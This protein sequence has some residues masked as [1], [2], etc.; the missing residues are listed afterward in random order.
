LSQQLA[1]LRENALDK[2]IYC[3]LAY[4]GVVVLLY[5]RRGVGDDHRVDRPARRMMLASSWAA[6]PLLR[7]HLLQVGNQVGDLL[8]P[9]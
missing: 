6:T 7:R 8:F 5:E 3:R 9:S 1:R 2:I 4:N